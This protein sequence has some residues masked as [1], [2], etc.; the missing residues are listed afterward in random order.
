MGE[1]PSTSAIKPAR[2]RSHAERFGDRCRGL[3]N[4]RTDTAR[5][6]QAGQGSGAMDEEN[7]KTTYQ[8]ILAGG[9]TRWNQG[10]DNK[11]PATVTGLDQTLF[12]LAR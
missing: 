11:S 10:R 2:M 12:W 8:K 5:S 3:R 7:D 6:E 4:Y 1:N 9:A